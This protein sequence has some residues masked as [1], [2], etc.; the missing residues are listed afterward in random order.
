MRSM[1]ALLISS[2]IAS[3]V[4]RICSARSAFAGC[5]KEK[6]QPRR[7]QARCKRR[8]KRKARLL[9]Q[10]PFGRRCNCFVKTFFFLAKEKRPRF[11]SRKF[12]IDESSQRTLMR[13]GAFSSEA[14][15]LRPR[16]CCYDRS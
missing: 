3:A 6:Q 12:I 9:P 1:V 10:H 7:T 16:R 14:K 15:R 5:V 2:S 11:R 8:Q 4:A 13:H